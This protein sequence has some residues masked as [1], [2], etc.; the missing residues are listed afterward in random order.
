M[1]PGWLFGLE[2]VAGDF[3]FVGSMFAW[4]RGR[5]RK[6]ILSN[7]ESGAATPIV[8]DV[9]VRLARVDRASPAHLKQA[10]M[11]TNVAKRVVDTQAFYY[12]AVA[13]R[14]P[15][16]FL[17]RE[18]KSFFQMLSNRTGKRSSPESGDPFLKF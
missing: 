14:H 7:W 3:A 18:M 17:H 1:I 9:L 8:D 5:N 12:L 13:V 2:S 11:I 4:A 15:D 6:R 16:S 10:R